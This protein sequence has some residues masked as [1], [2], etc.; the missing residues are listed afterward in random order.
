M[1]RPS[2]RDSSRA[3]PNDR[4]RTGGRARSPAASSSRPARAATTPASA[5]SAAG[6]SGPRHWLVKSEPACYSI[7]DLRR[8][9]STRWDGVRNHQAR[10]FMRDQ[11]RVGDLVLF[12]HSSAE[13]PGVAGVAR[14]AR[15]AYPDDS[16]WDRR[17]DHFDARSTP[18]RPVWVMVDLGFVE[19]FG[20]FVS[21]ADLRADPRLA[22]LLVLRPGQRLSVMPVE[23]AHFEIVRSIGR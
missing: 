8:D 17:S 5:K 9:G 12:Y 15:A 13:P 1:P 2:S 23:P 7:D 21:L 3:Q 6:A 14:I 16:A 20:R 19:K 18:E 11:M 4:S 10:N 22:G